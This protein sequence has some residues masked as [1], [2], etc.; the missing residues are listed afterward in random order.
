MWQLLGMDIIGK[1][2]AQSPPSPLGANPAHVALQ[3]RMVRQRV[4]L[5][6]VGQVV[7][8]GPGV[9]RLGVV[10]A[11]GDEHRVHADARMQPGQCCD[12]PAV[13]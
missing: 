13:C 1:K 11:D 6:F 8:R 2:P 5:A 12:L 10:P 7:D 3:I 9:E 4:A